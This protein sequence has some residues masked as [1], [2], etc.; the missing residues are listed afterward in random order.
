MKK[1]TIG[2][3]RDFDPETEYTVQF[4]CISTYIVGFQDAAGLTE[5]QIL[6]KAIERANN[7]FTSNGSLTLEGANNDGF[8][9]LTAHGIDRSTGVLVGSPPTMKPKLKLVKD[10]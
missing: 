3:A 9:A 10:N 4:E 5:R 8:F 6:R 2:G 7:T 1:R